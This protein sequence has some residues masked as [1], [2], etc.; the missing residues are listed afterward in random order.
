ME[1]AGYNEDM[2]V[3][4]RAHFDGRVIVPDEPLDV[5]VNQPLTVS[6][7]TPVPVPGDTASKLAALNRIASR[8]VPGVN[9]PA[10]ALSRESIYEDRV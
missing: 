8:A 3:R 5:P 1:T 7:D 2:S 9:L 10:E 6:I 4:L